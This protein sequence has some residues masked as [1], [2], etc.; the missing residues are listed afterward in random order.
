MGN[1]DWQQVVGGDAGRVESVGLI[2]SG[3]CDE[4]EVQV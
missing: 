3:V 1:A 4:V 2:L